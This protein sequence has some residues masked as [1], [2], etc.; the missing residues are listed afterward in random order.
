MK[1]IVLIVLFL[2]AV[3]FCARLLN[4]HLLLSSAE[5]LVS[6]FYNQYN[7]KDF[8]YIYDVLCD[9]KMHS[10][11]KPAVFQYMMQDSYA[12]LGPVQDRKK[13]R[14][15]EIH[16]QKDLFLSLEY[17]IKRAKISSA[18]KFVLIRRSKDWFVDSYEIRRAETKIVATKKP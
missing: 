1:K 11:M 18:E 7:Q 4:Q 14:W 3:F 13:I 9:Q 5:R 8:E 2:A 15:K 17:K 12:K 10:R 16:L 6:S